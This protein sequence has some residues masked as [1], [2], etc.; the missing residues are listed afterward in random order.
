M[1][2][3]LSAKMTEGFLKIIDKPEWNEISTKSKSCKYNGYEMMIIHVYVVLLQAL[4][5]H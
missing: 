4:R 3:T 5:K 2:S 1:R